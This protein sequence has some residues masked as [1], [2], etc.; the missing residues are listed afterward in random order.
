MKNLKLIY[1]TTALVFGLLL[2]QSCNDTVCEYPDMINNP[3]CP[4][5]PALGYMIV[6]MGGTTQASPTAM[7]LNTNPTLTAPFGANWLDPS[8]GVNQLTK[9]PTAQLNLATTGQIFGIAL[10]NAGG[11]YLSATNIYATDGYSAYLPAVGSGG[12]AGIYY[13][14]F[15]T[16]GI[17][18]ALVKTTTVASANT[19]GSALIPNTG[20]GFNSI[21]NIAYDK[22]SDQLFATNLEDGRI[23]RINPNTGIVLSIFDPFILD[24][25]I[26]GLAP[27]GEQL[28]GIGVQT[29]GGITSVFFARSSGGGVKE[30]WSIP[31]TSTGEF[32]ATQVGATKLFDDTAASSVLEIKNVGG[33]QDKVT[34]IAF[35]STGRMLLAERGNPHQSK[36]FEY[37]K[38]GTS[39]GIGNNFYLGATAGQPGANAAGG[40]DYGNRQ[41]GQS[42]FKCNDLV[43]GS[44]NYMTMPNSTIFYGVE[45]M[46]ASGNSATVTNNPATDLYIDYNGSY[47]TADKGGIGDVEIF[48]NR[49][50][51]K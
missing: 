27:F 28:W 36:V 16:P 20:G 51:C 10:D 37:V 21:G 41:T 8:L 7:I 18:S 30:I 9:V 33:T 11:I 17:T 25:G 46:S 22:V 13:T 26:A 44:S 15:S 5:N 35:S 45:G 12:T 34:D 43:W 42:T 48:K 3:L 1:R 14:D 47:S 23:Y 6:T 49:C 40:V 2:M 29:F 50:G 39:W 19:V 31:L 32:A 4:N 24:T 38:S